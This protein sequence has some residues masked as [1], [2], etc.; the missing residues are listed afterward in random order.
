MRKLFERNEKKEANSFERTAR[1]DSLKAR[2]C[3][4][5]DLVKLIIIFREKVSNWIQK[6]TNSLSKQG[7]NK[8]ENKEKRVR[9]IVKKLKE[10]LNIWGCKY[11]QN[12]ISRS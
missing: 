8:W 7:N 12:G 10:R 5:S 4:I 1:S 9:C 11:L 6:I 2:K 3:L